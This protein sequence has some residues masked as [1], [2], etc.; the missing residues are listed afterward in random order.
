METL[1]MND[2]QKVIYFMDEVENT[3]KQDFRSQVL[4]IFDRFFGYSK[5]HF[6]ICDDN[7][8]LTNVVSL[9]GNKKALEEYEYYYNLDYLIPKNVSSLL[10][11]K[12]VIKTF[13]KVS[14]KDYEKS[15]FYNDFMREYEYYEALGIYL[16]DRQKP[17]GLIEFLRSKDENP[18]Q[19]H[20]IRLLEI[21]S[22]FLTQEMK[23]FSTN[24]TK[25]AKEEQLGLS[26]WIKEKY[27]LTLKEL[28]VLYISQKGYS[29]A[30]IASQLYLSKNT[31]KKHLQN[32]YRKVDVTNRTSLCYKIN[33]LQKVRSQPK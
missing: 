31:V 23:F 32:I 8:D 15:I 7:S 21:L 16:F 24:S 2:Y 25:H 26:D 5:S 20:D 13:D 3:T 28:E 30:E 27:N 4:H 12:K 11:S 14:P 9:N 22:R 10:L 19:Q 29:N 1:S 6:W 18:F 33:T 17:L